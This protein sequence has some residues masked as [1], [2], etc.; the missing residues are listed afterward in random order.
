MTFRLSQSINQTILLSIPSLFED[1][2]CKPFKLLAAELH[3]L[4]L[5][6]DA[7]TERLRPDDFGE[8][9]SG[10]T[11][12]FVPFAQIAAVLVVTAAPRPAA[13]NGKPESRQ[14]TKHGTG[15]HDPAPSRSKRKR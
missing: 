6:S 5:E 3:G 14:A 8:Y 7:L 9:A 1:G 4:W 15:R 2:K 12:V 10:S 11:A 13:S